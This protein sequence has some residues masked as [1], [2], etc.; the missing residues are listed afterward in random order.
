MLL[1]LSVVRGKAIE[2]RQ[3]AE[4]FRSNQ[5][6]DQ[7]LARLASHIEAGAVTKAEIKDP[8]SGL[9][10]PAGSSRT[11]LFIAP[12]WDVVRGGDGSIRVDVSTAQAGTAISSFSS[13]IKL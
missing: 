5:R 12:H 8:M 1:N 3:L 10:H 2:A 4:K 13:R 9:P 6:K 11:R 7:I